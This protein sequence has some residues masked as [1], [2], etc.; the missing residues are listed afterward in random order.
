MLNSDSKTILIDLLRSHWG[1]HSLREHQV[2]PIYSLVNKEDTIALLPT[3]GGKSLCYQ[4]PAVFHG[5][6]CLVISPLIAL[7]EDQTNQL[8]INGLKASY[9]SGNLGANGIDRVLENA[10]LG[11]LDFLY[12]SP[13]RIEDAMFKA[14][15]NKLDVRTIIVDESHCISQWGHNFRPEYRK[16]VILKELYPNAVWGAYTATATPEVIKD[17]EDQ[18]QLNSP[19]IFKASSRRNNLS[20]QV[21]TW[22]DQEVEILHQ[23][24]TLV[25]KYP[26]SPGLVY[27]KTR[28]LADKFAE[29]LKSLGLNA[30]SF[31]AGLSA[32][33]KDSRQ[34]KWL[35]GSIQIMSCTSA[36]GMGIDKPN[37]RW[38]LHYNLPNSLESYIQESG[39]AGRDSLD[40][41]C[42]AFFDSDL[43]N[44]NIK[45]ISEQFPDI[46]TIRSVYQ[47]IADQGRVAIGDSHK[48]SFNFDR[49]LSTLGINRSALRA[50]LSILANSGYLV[51]S[52][53]KLNDGTVI[54][55]G[56]K[57]RLLNSGSDTQSSLAAQIMR[58]STSPTHEIDINLKQWSAKLS[59]PLENL[60]NALTSLDAQGF[61]DWSPNNGET[62]I[63]WPMARIAAAN[64]SIH[65]SQLTDRKS[66][67]MKMQEMV[68][69]FAE[70]TECRTAIL[71][72]YIDPSNTHEP[73][74][75]CDNCTWDEALA[76]NQ[77]K[78]HIESHE[79]ISAYE[80]IRKFPA[81]HRAEIALILRRLLDSKQIYTEG[82]KVFRSF[83]S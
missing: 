50:S 71:D 75:K 4:L 76:A 25:T 26:K 49:A 51:Q 8:K 14:R 78:Q 12:I 65:S 43:A 45:S 16:I 58:I 52:R 80:L 74:G 63:T 9:L 23:A 28:A 6:L 11:K 83:A 22:G 3:G 18:L 39:R 64:V 77:L 2:G 40:S 27:V 1:Y 48:C 41:E 15:A 13:E 56:G 61:I 42:I 17:I 21:N 19:N 68:H 36:F 59:C 82:T 5:G 20:Y 67:A 60:E 33:T 47:N 10:S 30:E 62:T 54:W 32:N 55:L 79:G 66:H 34:K 7:M 38:V 81:G 73:C 29:R 24:Q 44:N 70:S 72:K 57:N 37:V 31:H 53:P 35:K 69:K 46:N